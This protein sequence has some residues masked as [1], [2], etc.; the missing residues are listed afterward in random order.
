MKQLILFFSVILIGKG[1]FAQ[2]GGIFKPLPKPQQ[3]FGSPLKLSIDTTISGTNWTGFRLTGPMVLYSYNFSNQTS[4]VFTGVGVDYE[5]DKLQSTGRYY[6]TWAVGIGVYEG[7]QFA[8]TALSMVTSVGIHVALFNKYVVLGVLYNIT[9]K[10]FQ[11]AAG[12]GVT[13]VPTN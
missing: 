4:N 10:S 2:S 7:G 5:N 3:K 13:L 12:G 9:N 11:P 6:T 1:V 8:P